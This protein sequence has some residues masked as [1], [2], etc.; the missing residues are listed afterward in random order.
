MIFQG[1]IYSQKVKH[2][3]QCTLCPHMCVLHEGRTGLCGV[4]RN[5]GGKIR[6]KNFGLVSGFAIDPIEKK[7]LYNYF[8]GHKVLSIGSWGC[9]LKCNF[10]QNWQIS[11]TCNGETINGTPLSVQ[12]IVYKALEIEGNI[13]VAYSYNEPTVWIEY[14]LEIATLVKQNNM[15]NIMVSNGYINQQP[16]SDLLNV[17]D[18][19]NIDLKA[20][21][22]GFYREM[23]GGDLQFV[24]ASIK[25]IAKAGKHI[26]LTNL[27]I[28]GRNDNIE[29]FTDMINW[30]ADELG[31]HIVLHLSAYAPNYK[32][33]LPATCLEKLLELRAI[34]LQRLCNVYLGNVNAINVTKCC[35]CGAELIIR[36]HYSFEKSTLLVD[37]VCT[38]CST[39]LF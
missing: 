23:T 29:Q 6:S 1:S 11:Q 8:P 36:K 37:G 4:R 28:E 17:I 7:P 2:K 10:C 38:Q 12:D 14:M 31:S 22:N 20:F 34:A 25:Q 18:A 9:N 21:S 32:Q 3:V 26:E 33:A 27:V 5:L 16:L 13:G 39:K 30:I 35:G 19:F 15:K 24:L